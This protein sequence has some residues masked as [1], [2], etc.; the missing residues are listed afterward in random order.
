M[1]LIID[2]AFTCHFFRYAADTPLF[3]A[4]I[5]IRYF[6]AT[7]LALRFSLS[8]CFRLLFAMPLIIYAI[9]LYFFRLPLTITCLLLPSYAPALDSLVT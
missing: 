7:P 2:T 5:S 4:D 1:P 8:R 6:A 9:M 3:D